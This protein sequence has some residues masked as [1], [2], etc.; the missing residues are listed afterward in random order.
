MAIHAT[1]KDDEESYFY[2]YFQHGLDFLISG[3]THRVRKIIVHTNVPGTPLFQR[4]KRCPW[5]FAPNNRDNTLVAPTPEIRLTPSPTPDSDVSPSR[6]SGKKKKKKSEGEPSRTS[7][8]VQS[9]RPSVS[10][11]AMTFYDSIDILKTHLSPGTRHPPQPSM[12]LERTADLPHNELLT[13]PNA[14]TH[15]FAFDGVVCEASE[16]GDVLCVVLF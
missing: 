5:E 6:A 9:S 2:N 7:F 10:E 8:E 3:K 12:Q 14:T 16:V 4:Y 15:L 11:E 13:L 1:A